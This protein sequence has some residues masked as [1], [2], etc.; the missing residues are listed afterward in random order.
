MEAGNGEI[1][2]ARPSIIFLPLP[3]H[4]GV[5][6]QAAQALALQKDRIASFSLLDGVGDGPKWATTDDAKNAHRERNKTREKESDEK[7]WEEC[8]AWGGGAFCGLG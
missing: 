8:F 5:H 4:N 3:Q 7:L 6:K 1:R 2:V